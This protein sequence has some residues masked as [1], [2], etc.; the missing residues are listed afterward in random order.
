VF[1]TITGGVVYHHLSP[2]DF[3]TAGAYRCS[4]GR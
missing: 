4:R 2:I 1:V 3:Q